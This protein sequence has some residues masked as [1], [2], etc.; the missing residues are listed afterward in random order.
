[1]GNNQACICADNYLV[2]QQEHLLQGISDQH[3]F[4]ETT[5]IVEGHWQSSSAVD[6]APRTKRISAEADISNAL[7]AL[8]NWEFHS[9]DTSSVYLPEDLRR[10]AKS[11]ESN[12][13]IW[14]CAMDMG[15]A[16]LIA[17]SNDIRAFHI[18]S[19]MNKV[20]DILATNQCPM[21]QTLL[22]TWWWTAVNPAIRGHL[23][24]R[25]LQ[26]EAG[27]RC[28]ERLLDVF[29]D[30]EPAF[31]FAGAETFT[32]QLAQFRDE[33]KVLWGTGI[34]YRRVNKKFRTLAD[35]LE[36][37]LSQDYCDQEQDY[38]YESRDICFSQVSEQSY[39]EE[40]DS[41]LPDGLVGPE[42]NGRWTVE[43]LLSQ[44]KGHG[45]SIYE[46]I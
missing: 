41:D 34:S 11:F 14:K 4:D 3:A 38:P 9:F 27:R 25:V 10:L 33:A 2:E 18:S 16:G 40:Q 26:D 7:E 13:W 31:T 19:N 37:F 36:T 23:D 20:V 6:V 44:V 35:D 30:A 15:E 21:S 24:G 22:R 5:T 45:H 32:D 29:G 12:L 46:N 39:L 28:I 43:D 42:R 1:M 8:P 17:N